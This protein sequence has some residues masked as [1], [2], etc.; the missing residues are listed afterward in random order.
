MNPIR[1]KKLESEII[2]LISSAI[3]EGK[4]KDPRVF[5]PSFHRIEISEDLRY[6]KVYF[7]ALCN[8]NERKKLTQGLVS[9]AGF[10]SSL[11][12]KNLHLH[13]NPKFSF[14]WDN[15][16]IKSLEVNRLID[17]SAP[18]T[19]FEELHPDETDEDEDTDEESKEAESDDSETETTDSQSDFPAKENK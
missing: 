6:A 11:V 8:N 10:L 5:L 16:Y 4:V 2:R 18:K 17:E 9:C 1:M 7:T 3:L 14:V 15:N 13:T 12:G 19:L